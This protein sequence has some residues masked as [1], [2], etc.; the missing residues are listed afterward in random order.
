M[1]VMME[2]KKNNLSAV[3]HLQTSSR[4]ARAAWLNLCVSFKEASHQMSYFGQ[5]L[6]IYFSCERERLSNRLIM[7]LETQASPVPWGR[8]AGALGSASGSLRVPAPGGR[9]TPV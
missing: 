7:I 4:R 2:L 1:S 5:R 3:E 9:G 6:K 8:A